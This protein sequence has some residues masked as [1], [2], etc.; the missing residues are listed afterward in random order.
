VIEHSRVAADGVKAMIVTVVL[1]LVAVM[2]V[3]MRMTARECI[4]LE[5]TRTTL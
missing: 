5:H 3:V 4:Q 2:V 1:L